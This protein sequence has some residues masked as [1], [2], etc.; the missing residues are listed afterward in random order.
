MK[1]LSLLNT[2]FIPV[3]RNGKTFYMLLDSGCPFSFSNCI[4]EITSNDLGLQTTYHHNIPKQDN[5]FSQVLETSSRLLGLEVAGLLGLDFIQSFDNILINI[6]EQILDFNLPNFQA[7]FALDFN[8]TNIMFDVMLTSISPLSAGHDK[9]TVVD[10]GSFQCMAFQPIFNKYPVSRAWQG[11]TFTGPIDIDYYQNIELYF[12]DSYQGNYIFGVSPDLPSMPFDFIL[13]MNYIS[14]YELLIDLN[15]SKLRF[16]KS[17]APAL[18]NVNPTHTLGFQVVFENDKLVV[19]NV[20]PDCPNNIQANDIIEVDSIDMTQENKVNEIY[21]TLIQ[22][23]SNKPV[24]ARVN[25]E[26]RVL[27]KIELFE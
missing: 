17:Q 4:T 16:K 1:I 18:I 11:I 19:N 7:E 5:Q 24:K 2:V 6:R 15:N 21:N 10:T 27:V 13:G 26:E 9:T 12:N 20:R 22:S 25:G 23:S 14:Q 3:V 8:I